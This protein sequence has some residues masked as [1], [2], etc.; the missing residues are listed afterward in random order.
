MKSYVMRNAFL[1]VVHV[2][3]HHITCINIHALMS[4]QEDGFTFT[5]NIEENGLNA[6]DTVLGAP[7]ARRTSRSK[8]TQFSKLG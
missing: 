2:N 4:T 6:A 1:S 7:L 3:F 8:Q 5:R